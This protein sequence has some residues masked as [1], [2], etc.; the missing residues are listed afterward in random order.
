MR[1]LIKWYQTEV[2]T[3]KSI[4]SLKKLSIKQE[5]INKE[6]SD[7]IRFYF[8]NNPQDIN[9]PYTSIMEMITDTQIENLIL[10]KFDETQ[11]SNSY[12]LD[13]STLLQLGKTYI[14]I[15]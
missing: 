2:A 1:S 3:K 5:T 7:Y 10:D 12:L 13:W 9:P 11:I 14:K 4:E 8:L 6:Y 15:I